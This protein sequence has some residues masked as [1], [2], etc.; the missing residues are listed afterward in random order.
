MV[1]SIKDIKVSLGE[2]VEEEK[3]KQVIDPE[4]VYLKLKGELKKQF[5]N[6]EPVPGVVTSK[7]RSF[8]R[9]LE[10]NIESLGYEIQDKEYHYLEG[11]RD[12]DYRE[13]VGYIVG[14]K[15]GER[16]KTH[17]AVYAGI[18]SIFLGFL[19]MIGSVA[20][21]LV[22]IAIGILCFIIPYKQGIQLYYPGKA[23]D[24]LIVVFEG[25]ESSGVKKR[26][27]KLDEDVGDLK[28]VELKYRVAELDF[29]VGGDLQE[30]VDVIVKFLERREARTA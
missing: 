5:I 26:E 11:E 10:H 14:K 12:S 2:E 20:A 19:I 15:G 25:V 28:G 13:V 24:R 21:G 23:P 27:V 3:E 17:P 16:G 9:S 8:R 18:A 30:D 1:F 22:F 6:V 29:V 7:V 4:Q